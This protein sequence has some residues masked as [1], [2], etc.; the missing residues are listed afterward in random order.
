[1]SRLS[2]NDNGF[3]MMD[4]L[5]C[6]FLVLVMVG[7]VHFLG[8]NRMA[9]DSVKE[10]LGAEFIAQSWIDGMVMGDGRLAEGICEMNNTKYTVTASMD[11]ND[12]DIMIAEVS[13]ESHGQTKIY[14]L[15]RKIAQ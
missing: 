12:K 4:V 9:L 14:R 1:M 5:V 6:S 15:T 3:L 2:E 7:F 8:V 10:R 13:W 11:E